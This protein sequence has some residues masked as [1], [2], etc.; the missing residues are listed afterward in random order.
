MI[1]T[2]DHPILSHYL[3]ILR[4]KETKMAEFRMAADRIS[5]LLIV[6]A[7]QNIR[8]EPVTVETP[9]TTAVQSMINE[10]IIIAPILRAGLSMIDPFLRLWP[11]TQVFHIGLKRDEHTHLAHTYY[12]NIEHA[13]DPDN[14][15]VFI[16]DPMLA[17]GGSIDHACEFFKSRG[18]KHIEI[19]CIIAA[20]EG[21]KTIQ[22]KHPHIP[23]TVGAI[24]DQL[25]ENAYIVPGLGDAG[26]RF[27]GTH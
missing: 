19:I 6:F 17:T 9:I 26:D 27:F 21:L 5:S 3:A 1:T 25:N 7:T 15:R 22:T 24:D 20:P 18:Y 10:K 4:N 16:L 14:Q 8:L 13:T 12:N 11:D 2:P 23:I